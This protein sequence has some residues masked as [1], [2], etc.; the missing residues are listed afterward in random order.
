ML[1]SLYLYRF[2]WSLDFPRVCCKK[3]SKCHPWRDVFPCD[4]LRCYIIAF[5]ENKCTEPILKLRRALT[6]KSL[7]NFFQLYQVLWWDILFHIEKTLL[8]GNKCHQCC[9][10]E[11]LHLSMETKV[12]SK[13][14]INCS[15]LAHK[16][17][18]SYCFVCEKKAHGIYWVVIQ[19]WD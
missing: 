13:E 10:G 14:F 18:D 6:L 17:K 5:W 9:L 1:G 2:R 7:P 19:P 3:W 15:A 16:L 12:S 11:L 4:H 8:V